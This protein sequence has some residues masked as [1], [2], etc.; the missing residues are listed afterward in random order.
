MHIWGAWWTTWAGILLLV[1]NQRSRIPAFT[2]ESLCC[3]SFI[4]LVLISSIS[5]NIYLIA[6]I[7]PVCVLHPYIR[8]WSL[9]AFVRFC[10]SCDCW[11]AMYNL[12]IFH[13]H[14]T[15]RAAS[16]LKNGKVKVLFF[17]IVSRNACYTYDIFFDPYWLMIR[18]WTCAH[19]L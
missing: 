12:E 18:S 6:W 9:H 14:L 15:S 19:P 4:L 8:M 5:Q 11:Y 7:W 17:S 3:F 10:M 2:Y 13:F 1:T 16:D